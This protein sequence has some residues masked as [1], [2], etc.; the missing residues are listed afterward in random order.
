MSARQS[1]FPHLDQLLYLNHAAVAP[2][3]AVAQAAVERF[4]RENALLGA[5]N[6]PQWMETEQRL[7]QLLARL[8]NAPTAADIALVK[9]TSEALSFVA[10]GLSWRAGDNI[11][12]SDQEFPSNR[13]VWESLAQQGVALRQVDLASA[14][15]PEEALLN[16]VD[17]RTRL[18]T[19]SSI[20]YASGLRLDLET[21]G[22]YC[23]DH[24]IYF[25]VDAIQSLGAV[26]VDVQAIEADFLMADGH[27]WMLGPEG[28]ALFYCRAEIRDDLKLNQYGW[29]M[30]DRMGDYDQREWRVA[31]SA[32]R[33][34]C[35]SPNML[36][37]HALEASISLLLEEGMSRVE[38]GVLENARYLMEAIDR[39]PHL[40]RITDAS[41]GRH[42]GI[43]TFKAPGCDHGELYRQL[44]ASDVI[45]AHRGGGIR[46]SPHF[47][48]PKTQIDHALER[49][50]ELLGCC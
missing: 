5:K 17:E 38:A 34:E 44:M 47:Y 19:I 45:C 1:R 40:Q 12:T 50:D 35:G 23:R 10:Y 20:E 14:G 24:D 4:A 26:E 29:H 18:L 46:F 31:A 32:R 48:T 30:V 27:K 3:P 25:C 39:R 41:P 11:V 42:G 7:R 2:W 6:Y 9:N 28:L 16:R 36:G 37:I 22:R 15:T 21:L 43:V 33:F 13:I 8:I 49:V